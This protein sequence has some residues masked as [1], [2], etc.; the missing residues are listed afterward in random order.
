MNQR[1]QLLIEKSRLMDKL[2]SVNKRLFEVVF[3]SSVEEKQK[4]EATYNEVMKEIEEIQLIELQ[5]QTN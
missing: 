4:I 1:E 2:I 3:H 5:F